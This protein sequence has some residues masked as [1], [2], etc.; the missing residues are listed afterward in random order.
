MHIHLLGYS[1]ATLSRILDS[2]VLLGYKEDVQIIC[3]I[4][5]PAAISFRPPELNCKKM[6]WHEWKFDPASDQCLPAVSNPSV[7]KKVVEFFKDHFS[8]VE[9]NYTSVVHPAA[10]ISSTATLKPGCFVEPGTVIAS[11]AKLG[12]AV[13]VNRGSTIGHHVE[14]DDYVTVNPGAHIA[15]HCIVGPGARIG[16]GALIFDHISIGANSIIGGGSVVTKN[17]PD[18]VIAWGNPCT[19]IKNISLS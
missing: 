3:N 12:F 7:K 14:L 18:N 9:K 13:S 2:L 4:D 8:L 10:V 17:I 6:M 16:M 5:S 1:E 15:G 19:V 11:F